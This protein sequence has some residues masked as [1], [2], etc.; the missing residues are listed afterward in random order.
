MSVLFSDVM[1]VYNYHKNLDTGVENWNRTVVKGVQWVH[2]KK[3][4]TVSKGIQTEEWV[5]EITID[6]VRNYSRSP[7]VNSVSYMNMSK[8]ERQKC[9]TLDSKNGLDILVLGEC[10]ETVSNE[11]D[12]DNLRKLNQYVVIVSEVSDFRKRPRLKHIKVVAK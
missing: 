5:E 1:T 12:I 4:L 11:N 7:F 3:G 2:N 10:H 6:F 9:W 8:E